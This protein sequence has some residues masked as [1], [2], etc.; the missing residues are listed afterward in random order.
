M[1][2]LLHT[3]SSVFG[4]EQFRPLQREIIETTLA[5]R[6]V[7]ALLPTGGG[8]SMCFQLPA[9]HRPGLTFWKTLTRL[10]LVLPM[11]TT[12]AVVGLLAQ[13]MLNQKYGVINQMLGWIGVDYDSFIADPARSRHET[14]GGR[15]F[16]S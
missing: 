7:F 10:S 6:D 1:P 13:V 3:L 15:C 8:K 2:E 14:R 12:Y 5:G 11:A 16:S 4:Y 9:L